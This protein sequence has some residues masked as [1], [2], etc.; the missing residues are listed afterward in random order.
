MRFELVTAGLTSDQT[1]LEP[2]LYCDRRALVMNLPE[3]PRHDC[4]SKLHGFIENPVDFRILR[5]QFPDFSAMSLHES[6][7]TFFDRLV[8]EMPGICSDGMCSISTIDAFDGEVMVMDAAL[9]VTPENSA[10][11]RDTAL[12]DVFIL[13]QNHGGRE[14]EKQNNQQIIGC[15]CTRC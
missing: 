5:C 3:Q 6:K 8:E 13:T 12:M 11:A 2:S 14:P 9:A 10:A 7:A 4:C 1:P 15:G